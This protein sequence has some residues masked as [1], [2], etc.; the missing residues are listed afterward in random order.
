MSNYNSDDY[1]E[2][3]ILN[4][5]VE[6]SGIDK[7]TGD[8]LY[9]FTDEAKRVMPGLQEQLNEEFYNMITYL[10]EHGFIFMNIESENPMVAIAPKALNEEEVA[11]L[12]YY[13]RSALV[14]IKEALRI[15]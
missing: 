2:F 11:K 3:L 4:G 14:T 8:F 15:Q 12:P 1:F 9:A 13:Y 7:E 5:F 6:V 10:W